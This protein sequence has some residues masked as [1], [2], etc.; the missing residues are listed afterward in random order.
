[1]TFARKL[2][3]WR[4]KR[5]QSVA[6]TFLGISLDSYRGYEQGKREPHVTPSKAEM[7]MLMRTSAENGRKTYHD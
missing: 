3:L 1:M 2:K 5:T 6:A 7:L 4:G